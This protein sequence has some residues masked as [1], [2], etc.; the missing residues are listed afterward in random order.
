MNITASSR[1]LARTLGSTARL[2]LDRHKHAQSIIIHEPRFEHIPPAVALPMLCGHVR[3]ALRCPDN[4]TIALMHNYAKTPL[5]E[6]SLRYVGIDRYAVLTPNFRGAWR[7]SIKLTTILDYLQSGQCNSEYLLYADSRDALLRMDPG[8]AIELLQA[9]GCDCLFS[10][11]STCYGY[12]CMPEVRAWAQG[13]AAQHGAPE[14]YLNAGVFVGRTA[15]LQ[16]LLQEAVR[17]IVPT[18]FSRTEFRQH[19]FGGTL[20]QALPNY[21]MG[22]G[23]DQQILRWLH[24]HF[25]PRMQC[26]YA[27]RLAALR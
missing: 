18:E 3:G 12:Q 24:P 23:S 16:E 17:Y 22:V 27:G 7:D 13:N 25:Y 4:L 9:Q 10:A 6:Q 11:E 26:D 8:A 1:Q 21:P 5:M 2:L 15:F 20:C 14:L 19:L